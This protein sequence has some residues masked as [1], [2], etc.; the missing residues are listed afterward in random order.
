MIPPFHAN[1]LHLGM[2]C[3]IPAPVIGTEIHEVKFDQISRVGKSLLSGRCQMIL[4]HVTL[5]L[6]QVQSNRFCRKMETSSK[7][8]RHDPDRT[9]IVSSHHLATCISTNEKCDT[10]RVTASH[11]SVQPM[12]PIPPETCGLFPRVGGGV[13]TWVGSIRSFLVTWAS[14]LVGF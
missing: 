1:L 10:T 7:T 5:P 13:S 9:G 11:V 2:A 3:P 14:V 12:I 8:S 4:S 6:R